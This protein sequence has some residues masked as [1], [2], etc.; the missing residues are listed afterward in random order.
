[1]AAPRS[2]RPPCLQEALDQGKRALDYADRKLL[3]RQKRIV[4]SGKFPAP[5]PGRY[6]ILSQDEEDGIPPP[7]DTL[8]TGV[9]EAELES[10]RVAVAAVAH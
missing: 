7:R 5:P 6:E 9:D 2:I 3:P 8:P 10:L 4:D 1:M